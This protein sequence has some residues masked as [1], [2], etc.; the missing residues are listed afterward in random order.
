MFAD[1][2]HIKFHSG[3]LDGNNCGNILST[4]EKDD[5]RGYDPRSYANQRP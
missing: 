1:Y 4:D 5:S 2:R 3:L